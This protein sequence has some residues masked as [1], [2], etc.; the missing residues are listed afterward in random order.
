MGVEKAGFI[1]GIDYGTEYYE[2]E[3]LGSWKEDNDNDQFTIKLYINRIDDKQDIN[4]TRW[5]LDCKDGYTAEF[6][7]KDGYDSDDLDYNDPLN[8]IEKCFKLVLKNDSDNTV[9]KTYSVFATEYVNDY[10]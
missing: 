8:S 9:I 3:V 4:L 6:V 2:D 1:R 5:E 10:D 7:F